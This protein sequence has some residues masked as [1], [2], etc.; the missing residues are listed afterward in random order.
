MQF[1]ISV[2][3]TAQEHYWLQQ[4]IVQ[5]AHGILCFAHL[6]CDL[7][8]RAAISLSPEFQSACSMSKYTVLLRH[9][10]CIQVSDKCVKLVK[11]GWFDQQK[12][13]SGVSTLTNPKVHHAEAAAS[14]QALSIISM[15]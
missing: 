8:R 4:P 9:S 1:S 13:P 2:A 7:P 6:V 5:S 15:T 10:A 11:E 14:K 12:E 3:L